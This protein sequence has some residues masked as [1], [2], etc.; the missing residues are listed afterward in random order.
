MTTAEDVRVLWVLTESLTKGFHNENLAK[1][2]PFCLTEFV[3]SVKSSMTSHD[4]GASSDLKPDAH[5][6]KTSSY[7]GRESGTPDI[8]D[9]L[10]ELQIRADK[11]DDESMKKLAWHYENGV[12][13][14]CDL[15]KAFDLYTQ[16]FHGPSG[17]ISE[18][19]TDD[20]WTRN[21]EMIE[22]WLRLAEKGQA[23]SQNCVGLF[24]FVCKHNKEKAFEWFEKASKQGC[25]IAMYN[26]G[27]GFSKGEGVTQDFTKA[28]EWFSK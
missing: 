28:L 24:Q 1:V 3:A 13:V 15:N 11:G 20:T 2:V 26:V 17:N 12:G 14:K 5:P 21:E 25:D 7:E 10:F 18:A 8:G 4:S 16:A 9:T 6:A 27:W 23:G 19:L 22:T